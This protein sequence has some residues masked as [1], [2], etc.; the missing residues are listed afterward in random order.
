MGGARYDEGVVVA[1]RS[2]KGQ[3]WE[4][5]LQPGDIIYSINGEKVLDL[6]QMRSLVAGAKGEA[7]VLHVERCGELLFITAETK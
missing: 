7:V 5:T 6:E 3:M 2:R 1:A 4:Q